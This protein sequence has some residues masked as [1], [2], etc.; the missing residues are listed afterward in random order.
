MYNVFRKDRL[1]A[2]VGGSLLFVSNEMVLTSSWTTLVPISESCKFNA[3]ACHLSKQWG[4]DIGNL[5]IPEYRPP[6]IND[7]DNAAL[8]AIMADILSNDFQCCIIIG[9]F[10]F[11]DIKWPCSSSS[12]QNALF[13]N[14]VQDNFLQ[15]HILQ[16]R[17]RSSSSILFYFSTPGSWISELSVNEEFSNSLFNCLHVRLKES[18][19]TIEQ[20]SL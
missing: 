15:Q 5:Y 4:N 19:V 12:A 8:L 14:V 13:L 2:K 18:K 7:A 6:N 20:E 3:V 9:D 17:R 10:N 1:Y 16:P 11:L